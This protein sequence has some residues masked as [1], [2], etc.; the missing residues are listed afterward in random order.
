MTDLI[1]AESRHEAV[2]EQYFWPAVRKTLSD[3]DRLADHAIEQET[4]AKHVLDKLDHLDADEPEF[5]ELLARF[6]ADGRE[7]IR[8]EQEEVW[9]KLDAAL[10][11]TAMHELG[12]KMAA[13]KK[14]APT[15][16]HPHTPPNEAVLKTAGPAVAGL[17]KLR[18][19][20]TGRGKQQA[21]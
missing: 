10:D 11:A 3:G 6:I 13:A 15:R 2:E 21:D 18:D 19:A 1:M 7:H 5:E 16:P 17:D 14:T 9:P 20:A 12:D 4:K 8:Y